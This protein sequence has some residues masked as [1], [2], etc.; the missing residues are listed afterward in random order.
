MH[1]QG[2]P[3]LARSAVQPHLYSRSR[4]HWPAAYS[5]TKDTVKMVEFK[6]S[7]QEAKRRAVK[8]IERGDSIVLQK[9]AMAVPL[10]ATALNIK[11]K[12]RPRLKTK[13]DKGN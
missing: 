8:T 5:L 2:Y 10:E 7:A 9:R 6:G 13:D 11:E 3:Q 1:S 4:R 12:F